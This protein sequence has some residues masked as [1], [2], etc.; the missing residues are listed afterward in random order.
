MLFVSTLFFFYF[1]Q[2]SSVF[3]LMS[4]PHVVDA[5]E[6]RVPK[7][8]V[9]LSSSNF[10][11]PEGSASGL[12]AMGIR[13]GI[14]FDEK[15]DVTPSHVALSTEQM[16]QNSYY[17]GLAVHVTTAVGGHAA[18]LMEMDQN[19]SAVTARMC[20]IETGVASASNASGTARS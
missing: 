7:S 5:S 16:K 4:Y 13:P 6:R 12:D 1:R 8:P 20:K 2:P 11:S 18:G 15:F 3:G 9:H 19:F 17:H 14:T 10:V